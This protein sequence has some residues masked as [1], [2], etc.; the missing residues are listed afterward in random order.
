[1]YF[2]RGRYKSRFLRESGSFGEQLEVGRFVLVTCGD[3]YGGCGR[4]LP[5]P[6]RDDYGGCGRFAPSRAVDT[7][8]PSEARLPACRLHRPSWKGHH[9]RVDRQELAGRL[10]RAC[11]LRGTFVLRSGQVADFYFDKYMFESE[12]ELLRAVAELAATLVPE[13][14]EVLAG[15][16]LGGV[17]IATALS[18]ATGLPQVLV[19]KEAKTYGTAKLAEGPDV[20]GKQLLV[21]EDVVTT[22]GQVVM[23]VTELRRR[24]ALVSSVLCAIDRR[25]PGTDA[26]ADKLRAAGLDLVALFSAAELSGTTS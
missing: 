18:L 9:C 1:M 20:G 13:G 2:G 5:V 16:E 6:C 10:Q 7:R 25:P 4:L 21:I 26:A 12:P 14:T 23:S 8:A 11:Y 24:G 22:G 3:D 19:R 17:P 15:L